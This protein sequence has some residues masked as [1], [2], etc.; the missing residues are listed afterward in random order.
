MTRTRLVSLLSNLS[1][2]E[3]RVDLNDWAVN[4]IRDG[5]VKM[6]TTDGDRRDATA[7]ER[8]IFAAEEVARLEDLAFPLTEDGII[9]W[10][11]TRR[12]GS[13]F[14]TSRGTRLALFA[15]WATRRAA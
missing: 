3:T 1:D 13:R 9:A 10:M 5:Y 8:R 7:A 4:T 6:A 12:T 2:D 15:L 11:R 14:T